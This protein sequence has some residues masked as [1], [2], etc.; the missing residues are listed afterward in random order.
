[1]FESTGAILRFPFYLIGILTNCIVSG[2]TVIAGNFFSF[3]KLVF[4]LVWLPIAFVTL[5]F[6]NDK[7]GWE[8]YLSDLRFDDVESGFQHRQ[9]NLNA[10]L[11]GERQIESELG[12][13][14]WFFGV[15]ILSIGAYAMST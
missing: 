15:L 12:C 9:A 8:R 7:R 1:M 3:G 5:A 14:M 4:G 2:I 13:L 6:Q 10:W 11:V